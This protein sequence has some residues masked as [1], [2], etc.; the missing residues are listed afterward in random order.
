VARPLIRFR[1]QTFKHFQKAQA[2]TDYVLGEFPWQVR[3]GDSVEADDYVAP[4]YVISSETTA[5]ETVWSYGI[6]V[7]GSA[8]WRSFQLTGGPPRPRGV[9]ANQPSP[10]GG[11]VGGVWRRFL[12]LIAALIAVGAVLAAIRRPDIVFEQRYSYASNSIV[13]QA[14]VTHVFQVHGPETNVSVHIGTD[15]AEEASF[16]VSLINDDTGRALDFTEDVERSAV[17][18]ASNVPGGRYYLRIEPQMDAGTARVATMNY[19]ISVG[20]GG[21]S[22]FPLLIAAFLLLIPPIVTTIRR[23]SFENT[24]WQ[25]SDYGSMFTMSSS[26]D[27]GGD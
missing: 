17:I 23:F 10:Y 5:E 21:V 16:V 27:N 3:V 1:G 20:E 26:T 8:L 13:Q 2:I 19:T 25:E 6:Y 14:F 9:Y 18:T 11:K 15:T 12:L 4:P 24:R 7:D 22:W